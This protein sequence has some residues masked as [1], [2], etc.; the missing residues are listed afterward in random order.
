[1]KNILIISKISLITFLLFSCNSSEN[2][3]AY[4]A[5]THSRGDAT[6][7]VDESYKLLF[8]TLEYTFEG[9]RPDAKLDIQF[10]PENE[11]INALFMDKTKTICISRDLTKEEKAK[12]KRNRVEIVSNK[13]AKDGI[14]LIV[15]QENKDTLITVDEIK[16][17]LLGKT[18][19]WSTSQKDISIVFDH[20]NSANFA[21]FQNLTN[22]APWT[23]NV[24]ASKSSEEVIEYVKKNK[25]AIGI[26]GVN[27][28]SDEDDKRVLEY[29]KGIT[30]MSVAKTK[31]DEY[32]KPYQAF[33]Y[34]DEYALTREIWFINKGKIDGLNT[35]FVNFCVR[36]KGQLIIHK[37]CLVPAYPPMRQLRIITE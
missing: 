31:T 34:T 27:W 19:K 10:T 8:E 1:M 5:N 23:K 28:L 35:G 33:I 12:L 20:E 37:A 3:L 13:L 36:E 18:T 6:F 25:N 30:L 24:F 4:Q 2:P 15:N 21:Y 29:L 32:L 26:I 7:M 17:I 11:A 14:A 22:K 9:Q 16:N